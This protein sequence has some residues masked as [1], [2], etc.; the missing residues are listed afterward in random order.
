[1]LNIS[2]FIKRLYGKFSYNNIVRSLK[3]GKETKR[4]M[5]S[6]KTWLIWSL[7]LMVLTGCEEIHF[8]TTFEKNG[9]GVFS[10]V[11]VYPESSKTDES[12]KMDVEKCRE[13]GP[14]IWT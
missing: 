10:L 5:N 11:V 4:K 14:K 3:R 13:Y 1:M 8:Y 2:R 12:S 7:L 6:R 9:S